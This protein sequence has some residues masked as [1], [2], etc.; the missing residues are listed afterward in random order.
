[1][2]SLAFNANVRRKLLVAMRLKVL[3][4]FV[5]SLPFRRTGRVED[6]CTL[7]TA[8]TTKAL[9][10]FPHQLARHRSIVRISRFCGSRKTEQL[11]NPYW[12]SGLRGR[13][14]RLS[15]A[16]LGL[17][18]GRFSSGAKDAGEAWPLGALFI[19]RPAVLWGRFW[20]FAD[21]ASWVLCSR[22]QVWTVVIAKNNVKE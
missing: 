14:N 6:P 21:T 18:S 1:M 3:L 9:L 10:V 11:P 12:Q 22:S 13:L 4:H 15:T 2:S 16:A 19:G 7:G 20:A 5:E 17:P 8:P